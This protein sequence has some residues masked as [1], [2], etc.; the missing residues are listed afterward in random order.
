MSAVVIV[1]QKGLSMEEFKVFCRKYVDSKN[2]FRE[3][4]IYDVAYKCIQDIS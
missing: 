1:L 2:L 4:Y 3:L